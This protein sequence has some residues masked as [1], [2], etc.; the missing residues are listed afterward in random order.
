MQRANSEYTSTV[1][2]TGAPLHVGFA[3]IALPMRIL[4]VGLQYHAAV[5]KSVAKYSVQNGLSVSKHVG[6][7]GIANLPMVMSSLLIHHCIRLYTTVQPLLVADQKRLALTHQNPKCKDPP[8]P[9][10]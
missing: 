6:V 9:C 8:C 2:S 7:G 1:L 5:A 3:K 4:G 10:S